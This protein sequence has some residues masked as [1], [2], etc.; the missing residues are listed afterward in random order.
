MGLLITSDIRAIAEGRHLDLG[1]GPKPRNPFHR[2]EL[3]GVDVVQHESIDTSIVFK[4]ANLALQPIPFGTNE[5]DSVSAFDFIEHIPRILLRPGEN[6][7][8][9]PF[10]E[11]MNEVW[12][13]LKPGGVFYAVTPAYPSPEAFQDPTHV[14]IITSKTHEYFCG[15]DPFGA[16]YGFHGRFEAVEVRRVLKKNTY[17]KAG[18]LKQGLREWHRRFLKG[19]KAAHLLWVLKANK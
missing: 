4:K 16:L 9:F 17:G 11:L 5:F 6:E 15:D 2:R 10:I 8:F 13:V 7:T 18:R 19:Q 3:C 1:C 14:N 12:R